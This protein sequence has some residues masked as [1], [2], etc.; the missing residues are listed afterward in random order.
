MNNLHFMFVFLYSEFTDRIKIWLY[1]IMWLSEHE[2]SPWGKW[3]L[4]WDYKFAL[5]EQDVNNITF[6]W[7]NV[8]MGK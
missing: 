2:T 4:L 8:A 7:V 6:P 1:P 3:I 5:L